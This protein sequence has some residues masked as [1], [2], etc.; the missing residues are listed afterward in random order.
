MKT[1][2]ATYLDSD[3]SCGAHS[4]SHP[5]HVCSSLCPSSHSSLWRTLTS[6]SLAM[7]APLAR[8]KALVPQGGWSLHSIGPYSS[9]PSSECT[10]GTFMLCSFHRPSCC[11]CFIGPFSNEPRA[12]SAPRFSCP[13]IKSASHACN[14]VGTVQGRQQT[15]LPR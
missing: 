6:T 5:C 14:A 11:S 4:T 8:P 15:C 12:K 10:I 1:A 2:V 9:E 3:L 7:S 13:C